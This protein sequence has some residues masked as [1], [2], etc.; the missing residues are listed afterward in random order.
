M[1]D[2]YLRFGYNVREQRRVRGLSQ[3]QLGALCTMGRPTIAAIEAGRQGVTLL[4][5]VALSR[6]L[7]V[8]LG[9]LVDEGVVPGLEELA[10]GLYEHDLRIVRQLGGKS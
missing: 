3:E 9:N 6:A 2:L 8:L 1:E 5:A 10:Q 7:G 4:Q